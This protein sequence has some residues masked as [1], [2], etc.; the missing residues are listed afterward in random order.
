MGAPN[1]F[2]LPRAPSNP[3]TPLIRGLQTMTRKPN[4]AREGVL[5]IRTKNIYLRKINRFE[6]IY[7]KEY[8]IRGPLAK[9]FEDPLP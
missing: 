9:M 8:I 1:L 4:P 5:P 6:R 2:F 3:V 7:Q